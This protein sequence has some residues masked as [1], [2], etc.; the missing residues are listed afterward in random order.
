MK[1]ISDAKSL[2]SLSIKA[3]KH[4]IDLRELLEITCNL[5]F[6]VKNIHKAGIIIGDF[7][8]KQFMVKGKEVF[9]CDTDTC[10]FLYYNYSCPS[11]Y[12]NNFFIIVIKNRISCI[13]TIY[14]VF[15]L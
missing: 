7:H 3:A 12:S 10:I 8:P 9:V 4:S 14:P 5:A 15:F 2:E 11:G 6:L 13:I 1:K